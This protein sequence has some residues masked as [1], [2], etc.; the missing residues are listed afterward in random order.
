MDRKLPAH[1]G[2]AD[3]RKWRI[4]RSG[5][6]LGFQTDPTGAQ[7]LQSLRWRESSHH[8]ATTTNLPAPSPGGFGGGGY[9]EVT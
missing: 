9:I 8:S 3:T 7:S 1:P 5:P 2:F 4:L 6:P